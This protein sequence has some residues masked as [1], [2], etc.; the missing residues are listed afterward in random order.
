MKINE[1]TAEVSDYVKSVALE[2]IWLIYVKRIVQRSDSVCEA[3]TEVA[4]L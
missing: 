1:L 3:R 2:A 4:D